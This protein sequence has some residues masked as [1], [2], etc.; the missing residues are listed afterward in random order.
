MCSGMRQERWEDKGMG[1]KRGQVST[2]RNTAEMH[3]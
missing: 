3:P 1:P 2:V